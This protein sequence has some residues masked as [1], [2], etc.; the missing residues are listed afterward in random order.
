MR[1]PRGRRGWAVWVF[2]AAFAALAGRPAGE[3]G[4]E[5]R[6][7]LAGRVTTPEGAAVAGVTV[8]FSNGIASAVTDARGC[9]E[10]AAPADGTRCTVTPSKPGHAFVPTERAIWLS[11]D[12]A[13]ASFQAVAERMEKR[14]GSRRAFRDALAPLALNWF[15]INADAPFTATRAVTL[16]HQADGVPLYYKAS[17]LPTFTGAD[18]QSY[19]PFP[20]FNLSPGNDLKTVYFKVA[21]DFEESAPLMDDIV[22]NE[23]QV[24]ELTVNGPATR[25][26]VWPA[27][28]EDWFFFNA[29]TT[30]TYTVETWAGSLADNFVGLYAADQTTL[31]AQDNDSGDGA[32]GRIVQPLN[33]GTY[34][35]KV[36]A[37]NPADMGTYYVRV[38][39]GETTITILNPHGDPTAATQLEVGTSEVVF[40]SANPGVLEILCRF[41][42]NPGQVAG[43]ADKVRACIEPV[44][45]S[46]LAWQTLTGA[47]A[48]WAGT[49]A[50]R[51][52]T[53][54][55]TMGKPVYDPVTDRYELKV[56]F[57]GLPTA[58]S[59]FGPK[60]LWAQ[61]VDGTTVAASAEQLFEVFFPKTAANN[62]G[63]GRNAGPNW[64]YF[65]KTGNVCGTTTG[66]EYEVTPDF[67]FYLTGQ[68]HIN[69]GDAAPTVNTGPEFYQNDLG[70]TIEVAG[71]GLGPQCA[72]ETIA[73]ENLHRWIFETWAFLIASDE[74]DGESNG[75]PYDDP[76]DDGI[77]N[78]MEA[79]FL[80]ISTDTN[81]P[82]TYNMGFPYDTYGDQELRAR[83]IELTPGLTANPADDWAYPGSNSYPPYPRVA[84]PPED[85]DVPGGPGEPDDQGG[86]DDGQGNE[87]NPGDDVIIQHGTGRGDTQLANGGPGNDFIFQNGR[88]GPDAQ[89][90]NGGDGDDTIIQRGGRGFDGLTASG[91]A[92]NDAIYQRGM[93]GADTLTANAGDGADSIRQRG[94]ARADT[95]IANGGGGDDTLWQRG[96]SGRDTMVADG[97]DGDDTVWMFGKEGAD[98]L[99][100]EVSP[101]NDLAYLHG[102]DGFDTAAI[103]SNGHDFTLTDERGEVLYQRG[104]GGTRIQA[105]SIENLRV[106]G[107][108]GVT[109]VFAGAAR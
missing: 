59:G 81:D 14:R 101:G 98:A 63:T 93:R 70:D 41:A 32:S 34:F 109:V 43:V 1:F 12:E 16:N 33:P 29:A 54:H 106:I 87:G 53:A 21:D 13:E 35:V 17:E 108:D 23:P 7:R 77:P 26:K 20:V 72:L 5:G 56:V 30:D 89:T 105:R 104:A 27:G 68:D 24:V 40:S 96:G 103:N 91:G 86:G 36:R 44:G 102:G 18:W 38:T 28:E 99:T 3:A 2:L 31:L 4:S 37:N 55:P 6:C 82:D 57:T 65:W 97:G 11:G 95:L 45:G 50:G 51:P 76:D 67:G 60:R 62:A 73:H 74:A 75:D 80:G 48:T 100:Y 22:L 42:L 58:N 10:A 84:P 47:D 92:G 66:W 61:I 85:P 15:S 19:T 49:S 94:G 46:A 39:T 88:R 83:K 71:Q 90:A 9:Y 78:I 52:A 79:T 69:V 25:G 8:A 64:F 107:D